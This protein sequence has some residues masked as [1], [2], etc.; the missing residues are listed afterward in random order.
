MSAMT[1]LLENLRGISRTCGTRTTLAYLGAAV[2]VLLDVRRG[3][4]LAPADRKMAGRR[5]PYTVQGV[6]IE[7]DGRF[8]SGAREMYCRRVYFPTSAFDLV[9]GAAVVDLGANVGLFSLLAAKV[10]C[11]VLAVEA[12]RGFAREL[13]DLAARHDV[14]SRITVE[15]V[16]VGSGSG[17]FAGEKRVVASSDSE[18]FQPPVV[19][20]E[21]LLARNGFDCVDFLKTDIEG[22]EFDLFRDA[23]AWLASVRRIAM[24]VHPEFGSVDDLR[25]SIESLGLSVELRDNRLSVVGQLPPDGGYLFAIR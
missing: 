8:F 1:S 5:W 23:P 12:Q 7:L 2:S 13:T 14:A 21:A 4:S 25:A 22:S 6:T 10:G 19:S 17:I 11:R 16:L 15:N 18:G 3:R 9:P 24:E 20:M